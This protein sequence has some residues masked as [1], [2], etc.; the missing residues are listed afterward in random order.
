VQGLCFFRSRC[1]ASWSISIVGDWLQML[2][3]NYG[4]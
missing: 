2:M 4:A 1:A 3:S